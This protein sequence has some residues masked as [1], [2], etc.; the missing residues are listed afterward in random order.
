M[1]IPRDEL[2]QQRIASRRFTRGVAKAYLIA[3]AIG[4]LAGVVWVIAGLWH[5]HPLW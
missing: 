3:A 4:V 2:D 1:P 5:F